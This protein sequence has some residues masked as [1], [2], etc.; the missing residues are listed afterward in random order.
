MSRNGT[1]TYNLP[2]GNPVVT[3]TTITTTWANSTL[4]DISTALTGS[5]ASDGQT[6]ITGAL[7]MG[8]NKITNLAD[9]TNAQDAATK[10]YVDAKTNGTSAGSFTNLAY[11]GTLTGGTGVVNIGSGQ[12][13]KDASGN[14]GI[15]T[16]S[17]NSAGVSL[18]CTLNASNSTTG[19]IFEL[20]GAGT[21]YSYLFSN[22]SNTVLSS[23][24]A[25]PLIF[26]TTNTERM[27]ITSAGNIGVGTS[28]PIAVTGFNGITTSSTSGGFYKAVS[29]TGSITG[30]YGANNLDGSVA[31]GSDTNHPLYFFTNATERMRISTNGSISLGPVFTAAGAETTTQIQANDNAIIYSNANTTSNLVRQYFFNPNGT[32]GSI[33]T[34]GSNTTYGTSSDYRLKENIAPMTGAL[35]KVAQLKPCTYTWKADGEAGQGFIAHE[36]QAVIPDAVTGEKD[37]VN[38]DGTIKPQGIDASFLVATLTAAIQELKAEFDTY[39]ASHP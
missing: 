14:V 37:A 4:T 31:L 11:T 34:S 10:A 29:T 27:R 38:A 2:A 8:S 33:S 6:P 26:S 21:R 18:A 19:G 15:G 32:V 1:G 30:S 24:Q 35:S 12:V 23:V 16:S 7:Q 20:N 22:A 28:S 17:P 5:V 39:K 3:G 13:Y 36:L 25:L 9:P